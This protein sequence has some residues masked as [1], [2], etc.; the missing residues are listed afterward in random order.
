[1]WEQYVPLTGHP[2]YGRL[3]LSCLKVAGARGVWAWMCPRAWSSTRSIKARRRSQWIVCVTH[4]C[5][6]RLSS[7]TTR[8]SKVC[9][10]GTGC[11]CLGGMA[12]GCISNVIVQCSTSLEPK[13]FKQIES[14]GFAFGCAGLLMCGPCSSCVWLHYCH[15]FSSG[16]QVLL[17]LEAPKKTSQFNKNNK[18]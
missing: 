4:I 3:R 9:R 7:S 14:L 10:G 1:M 12:S 11:G 17:N 8:A 6:T 18:N 16:L 15:V 5:E 2:Q 13:C